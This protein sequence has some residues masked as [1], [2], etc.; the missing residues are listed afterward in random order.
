MEQSLLSNLKTL[1][2]L[3][4]F[5]FEVWKVSRQTSSMHMGFDVKEIERSKISLQFA[6]CESNTK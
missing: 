6:I 2:F 4:I 3:Y 5:L 1:D